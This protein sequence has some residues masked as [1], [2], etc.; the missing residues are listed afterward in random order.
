[1]KKLHAGE[2][3]R[4]N[5]GAAPSRHGLAIALA[6]ATAMSVGSVLPALAQSGTVQQEQVIEFDVPAGPLSSAL[7]RFGQQSGLQFNVG[8]DLTDGKR[9]AGVKGR[10]SAETALRTLLSGSGLTFRFA[11]PR[12][13]VIEAAPDV[14]DARVLGP[15][16]IEGAS[17]GSAVN[18]T[19]GSRDVTA[20]E[21]TNSY[22]TGAM[23]VAGKTPQS[24]KDTPQSVSVVTQQQLQDQ[25]ITDFRS[26]MDKATGIS[27]VAGN[28]SE[29]RR[30]YSRGFEITRVQVDGGAPLSISD[31]TVNGGTS[32]F[33]MSIYDHAE[34]L[35]GADGLFNGFGDPG[36]VINLVR[37]QP[38][39]HTQVI[40]EADYGSWSN[41]RFM[42][43]A[44]GPLGLSERLRG[45]VVV[46][47]EDRS[48]FYGVA[49][50]SRTTLYGIVD[51]LVG[52]NTVVRG[53]LNI[54]R[55]DSIP[56]GAGL[57]RYEDGSDLRLDRATCLCFPWN[58]RVAD[59]DEYFIGIDHDFN[60][61][62][63]AKLNVTSFKQFRTQKIGTVTRAVN[64]STLAG[65]VFAGGLT[66]TTGSDQLAADASV[67]GTFTMFGREQKLTLGANY[68]TADGAGGYSSAN[69]FASPPAQPVNI[70]DFNPWAYL[71]P[72][73]GQPT[74]FRKKHEISQYGAYVTLGLHLLDPLRLNLGVRYSHYEYDAIAHGL[75]TVVSPAIGCSAIGN[76]RRVT[77]TK[78]ETSDTSWPPLVAISYA[79]GKSVSAYASYTDIYQEQSTYVTNSGDPIDPLTGSNM[80]VG[81][82][83]ESR[84]GGLNASMS[85]FRLKQVNFPLFVG[86]GDYEDTFGVLP[87]GLHSCCYNNEADRER[88]S[89]GL[90]VEVTGQ[91]M[92]GLQVAF[93]Y[94]YNKTSQE[95]SYYGT[96]QGQPLVS[97]APEHLLKLWATYRFDSG[98][99]LS[100]LT[101]GAGVNSQSSSYT[102]GSACVEFRT[103]TNPE[104]SLTTQCL[105][106]APFEFTQGGYTVFS[107]RVAYQL[108]DSWSIALNLNNL[109]DKTYYRTVGTTVGGNWFGDPRSYMLS[110]RGRF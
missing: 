103:I 56:F 31:S 50:S 15:L 10:L 62:W 2:A 107:A 25:K 26:L 1:M 29:S 76:V 72:A 97:L 94:T 36:G 92:P 66:A 43:D 24:I 93:G 23:T 35:R 3:V 41:A 27:V 57:P 79:F 48:Y 74:T 99:Y 61:A 95:G 40:I 20:T 75:C 96:G 80:E 18:G 104:G 70:F 65:P 51:Y 42:V 58:T 22:T 87:D 98:E 37:K 32:S 7:L 33:D 54:T 109:T 60:K 34:I 45:R 38:L 16:R 106:S 105:R 78:Y 6:L 9:S 19:N 4:G 101:I 71:E 8:S 44:A 53:G 46:S 84:D 68:M 47:N 28:D 49:E 63:S 39:D 67:S 11:G 81:V 83:W 85:A 100:R 21:G 91:V 12:T 77:N 55:A 14:G 30:F 52:P 73:S 86:Y 90:D 17:S 108:T 82:K 88:L 64:S 5:N 13:V 110:L 59:T 102:S 89:K 69:F